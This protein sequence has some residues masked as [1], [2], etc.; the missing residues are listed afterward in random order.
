MRLNFACDNGLNLY[1]AP[2]QGAEP[3]TIFAG[4]QNAR[5]LAREPIAIVWY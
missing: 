5:E 3:W 1:G 2:N 4:Q